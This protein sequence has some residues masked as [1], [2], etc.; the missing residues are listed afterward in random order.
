MSSYLFGKK[1]KYFDALFSYANVKQVNERGVLFSPHLLKKT[2]RIKHGHAVNNR[3]FSIA[4]FPTLHCDGRDSE[5]KVYHQKHLIEDL[6]F[7]VNYLPKAEIARIC[8]VLVFLFSEALKNYGELQLKDFGSFKMFDKIRP[9]TRDIRTNVRFTGAR[10]KLSRGVWFSP[11]TQLLGVITPRCIRWGDFTN[12]SQMNYVWPNLFRLFNCA[13][14]HALRGKY[15]VQDV[16]KR[17]FTP[18]GYSQEYVD[19]L[20]R[21]F[22]SIKE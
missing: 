19:L 10:Y 4:S 20:S 6:S 17:D 3:M 13:K 7:F 21:N 1:D 9:T 12:R 2:Q 22:F 8:N 5:K 18:L 15:L 11:A 14:K 16:F